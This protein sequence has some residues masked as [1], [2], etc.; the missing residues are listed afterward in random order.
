MKGKAPD[1]RVSTVVNDP[2]NGKDRWTNI[3][4]GFQNSESITVLIDAFPVNGK[5]ILRKP[6]KIGEAE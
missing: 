1:Y 2:E 4:V 5:L 6:K 3:G